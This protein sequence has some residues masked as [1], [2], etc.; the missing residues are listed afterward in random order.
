[1]VTVRIDL[2][3][4]LGEMPGL[5]G[6]QLDSVLLSV[7]TSANIACGGHAGDRISM[8]RVASAAAERGIAI[9]A[10]VS[11]PDREQFG[12]RDLAFTPQALLDA[13]RE[14]VE[15]LFAAAAESGTAV[16]YLKAHGALYNSSVINDAPAALLVELA[17][18]YGL[19]VLTQSEGRLAQCAARAG[20]TVF[21][22]FFADRAYE[23]N[24]R[25][26][27]RDQDGAVLADAGAVVPRVLTAVRD[28]VV[29]SHDGACVNV[30]VDSVC[31]HGDTPGSMALAQQVRSA[32][33]AESLQIGPFV[34][35]LP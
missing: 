15:D 6:T 25:L 1:M 33:E 5:S 8:L 30:A 18:E 14:Q 23:A 10:H 20:V 22:E 24:G 26:Q 17:Q 4:D 32:L 16:R 13:L 35:A 3:A 7:V 34:D 11:Y 19:P 2:N 27:P 9:G 21:A 12:R 29:V 31:L 28:Q